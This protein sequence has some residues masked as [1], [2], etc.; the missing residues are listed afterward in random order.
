MNKDNIIDSFEK[1]YTYK[2]NVLDG[3]NLEAQSI[4]VKE[5]W[6]ISMQEHL[7]HALK[8]DASI[9]A[10]NELASIQRA[11]QEV[12]DRT[13]TKEN[14]I[15]YPD[16]GLIHPADALIAEVKSHYPEGLQDNVILNDM[17][18]SMRV[19]S[20]LDETPSERHESAARK[21]VAV[22]SAD[23]NDMSDPDM[24]DSVASEIS[25]GRALQGIR[26]IKSYSILALDSLDTAT[27]NAAYIGAISGSLDK[28]SVKAYREA[29]MYIDMAKAYNRMNE[30]PV[31]EIKAASNLLNAFVKRMQDGGLDKKLAHQIGVNI[32]NHLLGAMN[33]INDQKPKIN[34]KGLTDGLSITEIARN[35]LSKKQPTT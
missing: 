34:T 20:N 15:S 2:A 26:P 11:L 25:Q 28:A 4:V 33:S 9:E 30:S 6:R 32:E 27:D 14:V 10:I 3:L 13:P 19:A 8:G 31:E 22:N 17:A 5:F 12:L 16:G 35:S 21:G 1:T 23:L 29:S 18:T 24:S 7:I